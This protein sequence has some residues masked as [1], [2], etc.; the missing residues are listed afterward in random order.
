MSNVV[1]RNVLASLLAAAL[2]VVP[3]LTPAQT[4]ATLVVQDPWIRKPPPGLDSAALYFTVKNPWKRDFFIVGATSS[5]AANAMI[6]ASS[7]VEGQS[8][9][10]MQNNV[11]IPAGQTVAFAPA[12][13]RRSASS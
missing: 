9:M 5:L 1:R 8:Q 13:V 3:G 7:V 11:K 6:H 2:A 12:G 4:T 10:R